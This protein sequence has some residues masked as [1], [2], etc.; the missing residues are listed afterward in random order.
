LIVAAVEVLGLPIVAFVAFA[1]VGEGS[2]ARILG[3]PLAWRDTIK[4]GLQLG[5]FVDVLLILIIAVMLGAGPGARWLARTS[6]GNHTVLT[7]CA[8][9]TAAVLFALRKR[10]RVFYGMIE[11]AA[12]IGGLIVYPVAPAPA[13]MGLSTQT[14]AWGLGLLSLIYILV[15]GLDNIDVG[16][17]AGPA[18]KAS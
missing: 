18:R 8:I 12:S 15:R 4:M 1:I 3:K 5:L 2:K 17:S 7:G 14:V 16:R 10:Y 13:S 11:V 9:L 6:G